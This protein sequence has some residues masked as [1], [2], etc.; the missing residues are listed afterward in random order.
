MRGRERIGFTLDVH[1][2]T[3]FP[4]RTQAVAIA[5]NLLLVS[6]HTLCPKP[7][8][9]P[10]IGSM[11][12]PRIPILESFEMVTVLLPKH[13]DRTENG[14]RT[15]SPGQHPFGNGQD[16]VRSQIFIVPSFRLR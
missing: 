5:R 8:F 15:P 3:D 1:G 12:E 4:R 14:E 6:Q 11:K 9:P 10:Q 7:Y 16:S 2:W 13:A